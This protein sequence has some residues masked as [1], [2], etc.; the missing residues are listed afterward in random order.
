MSE[1]IMKRKFG[2]TFVLS[3]IA[4]VMIIV[5]PSL[6]WFREEVEVFGQS[7][8][9]LTVKG[10]ELGELAELVSWAGVSIFARGEYAVMLGAFALVLIMACFIVSS[11]RKLMASLIGIIAVL[12][13]GV[14]VEPTLKLVGEGTMPGEGVYLLFAG[15]LVLLIGAFRLPSAVRVEAPIKE[16][17]LPVTE[18]PEVAQ[19]HVPSEMPKVEP[20]PVEKATPTSLKCPNCGTENK[21]DAKFCQNCGASLVQS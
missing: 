11:K 1:Q 16:V 2:M 18:T 21:P 10:T 8:G 9:G 19:E 12:C 17:A 5:S 7:F 6:V 3:I 14:G 20:V 4:S 13:L 15:S